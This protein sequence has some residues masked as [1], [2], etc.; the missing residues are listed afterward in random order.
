MLKLILK[1]FKIIGLMLVMLILNPHR[2]LL[3]PLFLFSAF[4]SW[5]AGKLEDL[6]SWLADLTEAAKVKFW[7][8]GKPI[9]ES[10]DKEI[11]ELD[12]MIKKV[13]NDLRAK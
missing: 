8:V 11:N 4:G 5:L 1:L 2:A 3:I 9:Q 6:C 7:L 13:E 10:L 12:S